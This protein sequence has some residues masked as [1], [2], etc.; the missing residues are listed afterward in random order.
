MDERGIPG[1]LENENALDPRKPRSAVVSQENEIVTMIYCG[2]SPS[3]LK[4]GADGPHCLR[5][6]TSKWHVVLNSKCR[7]N[8][9]LLPSPPLKD[10][11]SFSARLKNGRVLHVSESSAITPVSLWS[12]V[13]SRPFLYG[14]LTP[15]CGERDFHPSL[16]KSGPQKDRS[17]KGVSRRTNH[18]CPR[19]PPPCSCPW[20]LQTFTNIKMYFIG[21]T[22]YA[23]SLLNTGAA[24]QELQRRWQPR[25]HCHRF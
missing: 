1:R 14:V 7:N 9:H 25:G 19:S 13:Q 23:Y 6:F 4:T 20:Q 24:H 3:P 10:V 17:K 22:P 11:L 5:T 18:R 2:C 8:F 16:L 12:R 15:C 21:L